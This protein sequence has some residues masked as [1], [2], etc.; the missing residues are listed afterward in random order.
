MIT[1][2]RSTTISCVLG[3]FRQGALESEVHN[4]VVFKNRKE[5]TF[6]RELLNLCGEEKWQSPAQLLEDYL[7][8]CQ[9][10]P[11]PPPDHPGYNKGTERVE[12]V[13]ARPQNDRN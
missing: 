4:M 7:R 12:E 1:K 9:H 5:K 3:H 2:G 8:F 11:P 10:P 6:S 13:L